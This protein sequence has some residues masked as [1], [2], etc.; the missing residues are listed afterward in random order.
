MVNAVGPTVTVGLVV[1]SATNE[2]EEAGTLTVDCALKV[3]G[4]A[5]LVELKLEQEPASARVQASV[6]RSRNSV[7]VRIFSSVWEGDRKG[8]VT[9]GTKQL[10]GAISRG[11]RSQAGESRH[12]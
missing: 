1:D 9:R 12:L 2:L 8:Y 6:A 11:L 5:K 7:F 3:E 10:C 4:A